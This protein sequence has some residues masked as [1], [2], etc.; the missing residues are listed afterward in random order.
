MSLLGN[1]YVDE[2][3]NFGLALSGGGVR[4]MAFHAGVLLYFS[5]RDYME[6]VGHISSVSGGSLLIGL[7]YKKNSYQWPSSDQYRSHTFESIKAELCSKS[8][9]RKMLQQLFYPDN[10]KYFLSRANVLA[11]VIE[12]EWGIEGAVGEIDSYPLWSING[13]TAENGKRFRFKHDTFGDYSLGYSNSGEFLLSEALAISAAFPGGIGPL[14]IDASKFTWKKRKRWSDPP[15]SEVVIEPEFKKLHI[16]DGGVYDNL[17]SE[18]LFDPGKGIPKYEDMLIMVSDAGLPLKKGFG[19]SR[20]NPFRLKRIVDIAM[21]QSRA[22]RV[23]S[24][25]AYLLDN[26]GYGAYMMI[27]QHPKEVLEDRRFNEDI[28][29]SPEEVKAASEYDTN[30]RQME[31]EDFDRIARHGYELIKAVDIRKAGW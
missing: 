22:L 4:A 9:Q 29:Q 30:L 21:E 1:P 17:G 20:L 16:Y 7:V 12:R 24:L 25:M 13:T 18:P 5:E 26:P 28:W 15:G 14:V 3:H 19:G 2:D 23:R 11:K 31:P 6:R 8:I 27:G 10:W